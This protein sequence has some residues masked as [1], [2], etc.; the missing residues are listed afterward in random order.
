MSRPKG[1]KDKNPTKPGKKRGRPRKNAIPEGPKRP[2][3]RPKKQRVLTTVVYGSHY[4]E[5]KPESTRE[6]T[7]SSIVIPIR[8]RYIIFRQTKTAIKDLFF[9]CDCP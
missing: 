8:K 9:L 1:S 4:I 2:R 6:T 7:A 3:G 5:G